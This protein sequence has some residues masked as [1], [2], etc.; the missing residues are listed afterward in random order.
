M[1]EQVLAGILEQC[2]A[3]GTCFCSL[4]EPLAYRPYADVESRIDALGKLQRELEM[5]GEVCTISLPMT[6]VLRL[7][8]SLACRYR[9][10]S[11][12]PQDLPTHL[13]CS[14]IERRSFGYTHTS[15]YR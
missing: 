3:N 6:V 7:I 8:L 13:E 11:P 15:V 14:P 9:H 4:F 1:A 12:Y 10:S 5:T 2:K